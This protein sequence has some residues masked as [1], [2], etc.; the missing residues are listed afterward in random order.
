MISACWWKFNSNATQ[1]KEIVDRDVCGL[2]IT[3]WIYC[4]PSVC[5]STHCFMKTLT[6]EISLVKI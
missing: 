3:N 1:R 6:E 5:S 4:R 2:S